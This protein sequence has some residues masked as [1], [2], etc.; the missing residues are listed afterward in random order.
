M[1]F[2]KAFRIH[3][4]TKKLM[5][6]QQRRLNS[7]VKDEELKKEIKIYHKLSYLYK[8]MHGKKHYPFAL[9]MSL[10]CLRI[11]AQINDSEAQFILGKRFLDEARW[12]KEL[13]DNKIFVSD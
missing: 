4:L 12:R 10:E 1:C 11:S 6:L 8:K 13:D 9:E 7:Q 2:F 3:R 5:A